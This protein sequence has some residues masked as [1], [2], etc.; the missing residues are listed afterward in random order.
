MKWDEDSRTHL[1]T[2]LNEANVLGLRMG[3]QNAFIDVLLHVSALPES[4][5]IDPDARR[6]LRL[7]SPSEVRIL[8]R[9]DQTAS[10]GYGTPIPLAD[11]NEVE[12]LFASLTWGDSMYGW[13][14]FDNP[15]LVKDWPPQ[16]SLTIR[17]QA[18]PA[19]HT[20]YWFSECGRQDGDGTNSYC[21]EGTV[22]FEDLVV[23]RADGTVQPLDVFVAEGRG[24][25]EAM[26]ASDQRLSVE[27]QRRSQVGTP[28]WRPW[29]S[30]GTTATGALRES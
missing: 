3:P 22:V 12:A 9:T 13:K 17:L 2:A 15:D 27:A 11:L 28:K 7:L 30:T 25:W 16:P 4:G 29:A 21:I 24:Y 8:L 14:F 19:A 23:L 20:F 1:E 18:S 6:A 5:P 10:D 26:Y